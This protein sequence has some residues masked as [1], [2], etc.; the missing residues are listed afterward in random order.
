MG[1][2]KLMK[3][4]TMREK[5][6]EDEL[7]GWRFEINILIW[8]RIVLYYCCIYYHDY[9][10][11][12]FKYTSV[13]IKLQGVGFGFLFFA[14]ALSQV[15]GNRMN[16]YFSIASVLLW[17]ASVYAFVPMIV[18]KIINNVISTI[19]FVTSMLGYALSLLWM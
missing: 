7:A 8:M 3:Y 15:I 18:G 13:A 14:N 10:V 2:L 11:K 16:D 6:V 19:R 17:T 9:L 12:Y 1:C 4:R 5:G